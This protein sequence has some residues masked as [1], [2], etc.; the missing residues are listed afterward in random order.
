MISAI[1]AIIFILYLKLGKESEN[2][3]FEITIF[4]ILAVFLL[5]LIIVLFI[6]FLKWFIEKKLGVKLSLAFFDKL[7]LV[8][9]SI[10][11]LYFIFYQSDRHHDDSEDLIFLIS[12]LISFGAITT[13]IFRHLSKIK[14]KRPLPPSMGSL[15]EIQ[16]LSANRTIYI[17][18]DSTKYYFIPTQFRLSYDNNKKPIEIYS[19]IDGVTGIGN[20][21]F[22]IRFEPFW[23]EL[24]SFFFQRKNTRKD[25]TLNSIL[26]LCKE[27]NIIIKKQ[28][29]HTEVGNININVID[30]KYLILTV[31]YKNTD[32]GGFVR[33]ALLDVEMIKKNI[34][35]SLNLILKPNLP[36]GKDYPV[37]L[38]TQLNNLQLSG[39]KATF[40]NNS[41]K[42]QNLSNHTIKLNSLFFFERPVSNTSWYFN[43][44]ISERN[45]I[46]PLKDEFFDWSNISNIISS[47][48]TTRPDFDVNNIKDIIADSEIFAI[49]DGD[50]AMEEY[51]PINTENLYLTIVFDFAYDLIDESISEFIIH[52]KISKTSSFHDEKIEIKDK[53]LVLTNNRCMVKLP[54]GILTYT[55]PNDI[56]M[57][58]SIGEVSNGGLERVK[59]APTSI[60]LKDSNIVNVNL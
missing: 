19:T 1:A 25:F 45:I 44:S 40:S 14:T 27:E 16:T 38:I 58:Y 32:D 47:V 11:T 52:S 12:S 56:F 55:K 60:S 54:L 30:F 49:T 51:V 57:E 20:I 17:F 43:Y 26:L 4:L 48:S 31:N 22:K 8:V 23:T 46:K 2:A 7:L 34:G 9:L 59:V 41:I 35:V 21:E 18:E 3:V 24:D 13:L 39:I 5:F 28:D 33:N 53:K 42:V 10:Y 36:Y 6:R 50:I 29:F 37:S 15:K